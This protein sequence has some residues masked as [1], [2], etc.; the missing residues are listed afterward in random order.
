MDLRSSD[1]RSP[2]NLIEHTFNLG[3]QLP[4]DLFEKT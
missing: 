1:L 3:G 2:S 4:E